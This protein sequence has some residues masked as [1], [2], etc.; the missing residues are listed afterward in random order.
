LKA[1]PGA[2]AV[3]LDIEQINPPLLNGFTQVGRQEWES[4][5]ALRPQAHA[6][7]YSDPETKTDLLYICADEL[8]P[9]SWSPMQGRKFKLIFSDALHEPD[10]LL[11][12]FAKICE[13][14]LLDG[15]QFAMV[16]DDLLPPLRKSFRYIAD[17]LQRKYGRERLVSRVL[18]VNGW[19]G[20]AE[21]PHTIGLVTYGVDL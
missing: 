13:Y 10:A 5:S 11:F 2:S 14:E 20:S 4:A 7:H 15:T 16:W 18:N 8:Q 1:N 21:P 9:E 6:C 19:L 17:E 3:G 12:E